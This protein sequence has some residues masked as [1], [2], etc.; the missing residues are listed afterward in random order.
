M[1]SGVPAVIIPV[2]GEIAKTP[3]AV[4]RCQ[5]RWSGLLPFSASSAISAVTGPFGSLGSFGVVRVLLGPPPGRILRKILRFIGPNRP[6]RDTRL[7]KTEYHGPRPGVPQNAEP[8]SDMAFWTQDSV[9]AMAG[10][11][12]AVVL[13]PDAIAR[14]METCAMKLLRWPRDERAVPHAACRPPDRL[15]PDVGGLRPCSRA[16]GTGLQRGCAPPS[17]CV[18]TS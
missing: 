3:T 1:S 7:S 18:G 12:Y 8:R 9:P 13:A 14:R 5:S 16:C 6:I 2:W 11:L 10:E 15:N 17:R 4:A